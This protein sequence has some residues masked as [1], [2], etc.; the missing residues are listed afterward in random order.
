M[1]DDTSGES[2]HISAW[3]NRPAAEVYRYAAD[4]AHLPQWAAGLASGE[5]TRVGD[6]WVAQSP[7]GEITIEFT[8]ANDFGVLDH[9]VTMPSGEPV[10]NPLRVVP[11]GKAWSE[12]VF[13]LRR[14]AGMSEQEYAADAAAVA[15]DLAA[16][17]RILER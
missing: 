4:P 1:D 6:T 9:V 12:V 3:I 15:A 8:P 5:L 16:L 14:R 17:K 13:T 2:R 7:M 11:A 10:F